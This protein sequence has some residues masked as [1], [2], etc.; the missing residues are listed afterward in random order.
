MVNIM[1]VCR[2]KLLI[3][4]SAFSSSSTIFIYSLQGQYISNLTVIAKRGLFDATW[5]PSCNIVYTTMFTSEVV[6]VSPEGEVKVVYTKLPSPKH[7]SVSNDNTIY[8]TDT[9]KGVHMSLDDGYIWVFVFNHHDRKSHLWRA[10]K[11]SFDRFDTFW[12]L[13]GNAG[14]MSG[15]YTFTKDVNM[16]WKYISVLPLTDSR[17]D[18]RITHMV[19]DGNRTILA[20]LGDNAIYAVSSNGNFRWLIKLSNFT[21]S[22]LSCLAI[23]RENQLLYVAV[24]HVDLKNTIM[25]FEWKS[26]ITG[27]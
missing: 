17:V 24:Q 8:V 20:L 19:F 9:L 26:K 13:P 1:A 15:V 23:G 6:V 7:L 2:D 16:T 25:V 11:I 21:Q 27:D 12:T 22:E 14:S 5:T 4:S 10:I 18:T 3:S